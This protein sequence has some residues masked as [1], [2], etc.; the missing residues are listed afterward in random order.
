M[1]MVRKAV[2]LHDECVQRRRVLQMEIE[3]LL[4]CSLEIASS[5]Y[6]QTTWMV[7]LLCSM[8][9]VGWEW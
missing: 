7:E 8:V 2:K 4:A 9:L 6:S 3:G 5:G 1:E